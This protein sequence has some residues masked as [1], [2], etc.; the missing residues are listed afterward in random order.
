M[1]ERTHVSF[2]P[3]DF[4][5]GLE[6]KFRN[7][8]GLSFGALLGLT[9]TALG[10]DAFT[11]AQPSVYDWS[12]FYAGAHI[13]YGD[14]TADIWTTALDPVGVPYAATAYSSFG[15]DGALGGVQAGFNMQWDRVVLGV[16]GEYS[17]SGV[18]GS[19]NFDA[20]RPEAIAGGKIT[21]LAAIK[22]RAG[23]AFDRTLLF[24]TA[25][26]AIGWNEGFANN[27]WSKAPAV[28]VATGKS[29]LSGY[30]VGLGAEYALTDRISL[31]GEYNYYGFGRGDFD[32]TSSAYPPGAVLRTQ[33]KLSLHVFKAG[34]NYHF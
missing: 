25:G 6:M 27:F 2:L 22:A 12:G 20:T 16:E 11:G 13:G 23:I 15:S 26:Y 19:F 9:S 30:V 33:P 29:T 17:A 21:A 28:D 8:A 24:G 32:M 7:I 10:A 3:A 18:K 4:G 31:K 5:E 14:G 34:L 1:R